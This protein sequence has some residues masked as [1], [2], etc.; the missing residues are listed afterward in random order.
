MS[1]RSEYSANLALAA[2]ASLPAFGD[3]PAPGPFALVVTVENKGMK[4]WLRGTTWAFHADRA[5]VFHTDAEAHAAI[6]RAERFMPVALA[7]R[8]RVEQST[9]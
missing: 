9:L 8:V 3:F 2:S 1:N 5:D 6:A 7:R 4:F